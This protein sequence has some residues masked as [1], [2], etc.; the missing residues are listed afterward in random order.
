[1]YSNLFVSGYV[2]SEDENKALDTM[3]TGTNIMME[4]TQL[5]TEMSRYHYID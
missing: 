3:V 1:M 2:Q 4:N 5:I